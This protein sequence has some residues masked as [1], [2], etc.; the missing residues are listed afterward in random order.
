MSMR[1]KVTKWRNVG[2][3]CAER[4]TDYGEL[5][6]VELEETRKC[7]VRELSALVALAV[8]DLF[9][10]QNEVVIV[11]VPELLRPPYD[12]RRVVWVDG[13]IA[14]ASRIIH[15]RIVRDLDIRHDPTLS[16]I[17]KVE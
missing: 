10:G 11:N 4:A 7:L 15:A 13:D 12:L 17:R 16:I 14:F 3:F 8:A 1:S 9:G 5:L 6:G 2:R